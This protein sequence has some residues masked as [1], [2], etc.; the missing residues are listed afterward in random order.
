MA[1]FHGHDNLIFSH[2]KQITK[3]DG[4]KMGQLKS[5]QIDEWIAEYP[6]IAQANSKNMKQ[7]KPTSEG[8]YGTCK[9]CG[10]KKPRVDTLL[11]WQSNDAHDYVRLCLDCYKEAT[12]C[13]K[14]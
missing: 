14:P 12:K 6:E 7:T 5:G 9:K 2:Q 13:Q 11:M 4:G 10:I 8:A 3:L 1:L